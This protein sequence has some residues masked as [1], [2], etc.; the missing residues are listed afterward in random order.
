MIR[1]M[2]RAIARHMMASGLYTA[3]IQP[4]DDIIRTV[5]GVS[6]PAPPPA[7]VGEPRPA[8]A[9]EAARV[10]PRADRCPGRCGGSC[11]RG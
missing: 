11:V 4:S 6:D 10:V 9:R 5:L 1:R 3:P 7:P 8:L 2:I